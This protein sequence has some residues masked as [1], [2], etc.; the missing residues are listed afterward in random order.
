[1]VRDKSL[2]AGF[3]AFSGM[4]ILVE[5]DYMSFLSGLYPVLLDKAFDITCILIPSLNIKK[6]PL[7][8]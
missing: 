3:D 8:F 1:M 6:A 2:I 5:W 7:K 4:E